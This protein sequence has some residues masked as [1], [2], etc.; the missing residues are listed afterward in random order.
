[1]DDNQLHDEWRD[2]CVWLEVRAK[3]M[4]HRTNEPDFKEIIQ[5]DLEAFSK[6]PRPK[7]EK[8]L[9]ALRRH[10]EALANSWETTIASRLPDDR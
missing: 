9:E 8:A 2:L 6:R 10:L 5:Y 7:S 3:Q 4:I 1:M